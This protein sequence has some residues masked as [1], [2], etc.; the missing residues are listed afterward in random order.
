MKIAPRAVERAGKHYC[1]HPLWNGLAGCYVKVIE[2]FRM[3]DDIFPGITR[4][5][6]DSEVKKGD[7]LVGDFHGGLNYGFMYDGTD[8][9]KVRVLEVDGDVLEGTVQRPGGEEGKEIGYFR[10]EIWF[11]ISHKFAVY[12]SGKPAKNTLR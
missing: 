7:V 4:I 11:F 10:N 3:L 12:S 5:I 8:P 1:G 2:R 6:H 9:A